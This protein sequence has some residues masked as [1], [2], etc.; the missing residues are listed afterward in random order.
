MRKLLV[1]L[2]SVVFI[3]SIT[4]FVG[5]QEKGQTEK[6]SPAAQSGEVSKEKAPKPEASKS[7]FS[8]PSQAKKVKAKA[9]KYRL[10]GLV[11][12]V[13]PIKNKISIK[14]S[15]V[16]KER[17]VTLTVDKKL[18]KVLAKLKVGDEV[19][20]W[21]VGNKVTALQKVF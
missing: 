20:V 18:T 1:L 2:M 8:K 12:Y 14:Q 6:P 7:E 10:G 16:R 11:T 4:G 17:K 13:D 9:K 21:V 15:K 19:N 3:L 5:T